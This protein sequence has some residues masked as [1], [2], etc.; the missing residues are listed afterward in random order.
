MVSH[1]DQQRLATGSRAMRLAPARTLA[2]KK[3]QLAQ[4]WDAARAMQSLDDL[5][6]P[7]AN[8]KAMRDM[9]E[10]MRR[11]QALEQ[12]IR[13]EEEAKPAEGG[14]AAFIRRTVTDWLGGRYSR[15]LGDGLNPDYV[16]PKELE[17][18]VKTLTDVVGCAVGAERQA[19]A[20]LAEARSFEDNTTIRDAGVMQEIAAA[21]RNRGMPS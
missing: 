2:A 19:C 13:E 1:I 6:S 14:D 10:L 9:D 15:E 8:E 4:L 12:E 20:E 5:G 21:I 16:G 7:A 18:L 11:A 17:R 3:G